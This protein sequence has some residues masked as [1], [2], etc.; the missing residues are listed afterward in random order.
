MTAGVAVAAL[1]FSYA[2]ETAPA[3]D[4]VTLSAD[5]GEVLAVV[6][7]SGSGKSTLL[8]LVAGLLTP[9]AGS[10]HV[11]GTDVTALS[12]EDRSAAMVFQGFALFP[13][14]DVAA[15]IGFGLKARR[16]P[17]AVRA[18]RVAT[19]AERLGLERLLSRRPAELSG[20]ERQ[21]V[22][23]AR[24]LLRDPAVFLLDE[25]LS[26]LDPVLRTSARRQLDALLR[27]DGRCAIYVTHDQHEAMTLGDRVAV[28]RDGRLEQVGSPQELYQRPANTFVATF[29]G[30][31]PM[32]LVPAG[33]AGLPA[34]AGVS[35]L[36]V[37]AEDVRLVPGEDAEVLAVDDLGHER[38]VELGL[39]GET[40]T[41]RLP[42]GSPLRRGDRTSVEVLGWRGFD[43]AG[44][45]V[46]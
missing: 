41:A 39:H 19:V 13:H 26:S 32:S 18:E 33:H 23:L 17:R 43:A 27:A 25:P 31:P 22:A 2:Q 11:A 44:D 35:M 30:T 8:R 12:P 24:A 46:S 34:P 21:R 10:V 45:A 38:M 9:S 42:A 15:N 20:G 5:P 7:P 16:V 3:V 40:L 14:L 1:S 4:D 6:G 28:L 29:V 37:H 36:G